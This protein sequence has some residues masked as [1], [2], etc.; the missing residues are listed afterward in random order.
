[1]AIVSTLVAKSRGVHDAALNLNAKA[2]ELRQTLAGVWD[3]KPAT[4]EAPDPKST[5]QLDMKNDSG[6]SVVGNEDERVKVETVHFAPGGKYRSIVKLFIHY[7]FQDPGKWAMGTGWLIKPDLL[8]TAGHCTYDWSHSLGRATEIKA[9]TGYKGKD[10]I[11]DPSVQFRTGKRIVTTAGWL[12]TRGSKAYDV[13]FIQVNKPF[14]GIVPITYVE[15][16]Q[17]GDVTIGV[18]GYPG[19]L[20]NEITGEKGAFMYE[21]FLPTKFNLATQADTMLEYQIDTYGGN[22]GSPVLRQPDLASIGAHVYG[23]TYNSA[24]VIGRFGNPYND[25]VTAF[26]VPLTNDGLNLIP[27]HAETT[28]SVS[29]SGQKDRTIGG[30]APPPMFQPVGEPK[31]VPKFLEQPTIVPNRSGMNGAGTYGKG[32]IQNGLH[33]GDE[34]SFLDVL[35]VAVRT[36]APLLGGALKTGLPLVLGPVG[37]PVGA[38][39]GLVLNSAAKLAETTDAESIFDQAN[40]QAGTVERAILA[41]AAFTAMQKVQWHP[42]DQESIFSDMKDYIVKAAPTIKKV[43]PHVMGAMMEPALRIALNSLHNYNQ[44]GAAGA[45][46]FEDHAEEPFRPAFQYPSK[47]N[48]RTDRNA[49]AFITGLHQALSNG[50]ESLDTESEE[51]FF[52]VIKAGIRLA[53]QGLSVVAEKGLPL[54]AQALTAES[55]EATEAMEASPTGLSADDLSK[56]ALASEAALQALMKMPPQRLQEEGFFETMADVVKKI[57]PVVMMVAPTVIRNLSPTVGKLL[58]GMTG[59]E[60]IMIGGYQGGYT[61][62]KTLANKR[63]MPQLRKVQSVEDFLTKASKWHA[64]TTT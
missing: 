63:S 59:Q 25:Y 16:P 6:E 7:E 52:D 34:E 60:S 55:A 36:A 1:M 38:L 15:T 21:M 23:G 10:S 2:F 27:V 45:E 12:K 46:A 24:S 14:T 4:T 43:A 50:Q 53:G 40:V 31:S 22:S 47:I 30:A 51:G 44:K 29:V 19:D 33:A 18:V 26:D 32:A 41:E 37:G 5:F 17:Q 57:A 13:G 8:V 54:I 49:E 35:K 11:Q 42:D 39:A 48:Q 28:A 64:T 9:Y 3:L 20:K 58:E 61:A 62:P 56:R